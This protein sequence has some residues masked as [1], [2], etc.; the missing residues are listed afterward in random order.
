MEKNE[1]GKSGALGNVLMMIAI[2]MQ[3]VSLFYKGRG[4]ENDVLDIAA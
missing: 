3:L 2:R 1:K 4:R